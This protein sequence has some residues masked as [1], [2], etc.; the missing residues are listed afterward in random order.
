VSASPIPVVTPERHICVDAGRPLAQQP[1]IGHNR[2]HPDLEPVLSVSPGDTFTLETIDSSD[3][4]ITPSTSVS[5][6]EAFPMGR[7][8]PLTG[9]V[10]VAGATPGDV[11]E[12]EILD[13]S[14]GPFGSAAITPGEGLLPD[15]LEAPLLALFELSD[16]GARSAQLPGITVPAAMFPGVLGVAP[17]AAEVRAA[18]EREEDGLDHSARREIAAA[19]A[20]IPT[21][22]ADG[23]RTIPPR[24]NGGNI[25]VKELTA[26]ARL[27]LPVAVSGALLSTGDLH[28]AQG[29]GELAASSIEMSGAVTM[30]CHVHPRPSWGPSA[31]LVI[32]PSRTDAGTVLTV[33]VGLG[34]YHRCAAAGLADAAREAAERMILWL[35]AVTE[36][37]TAQAYLLLSIAGNLKISQLVNDPNPVVCLSLPHSVFDTA[38]ERFPIEKV[39][40]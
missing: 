36:L 20:A 29:D 24:Y 3:A 1:E 37:S 35:R 32:A 26:G 4:F 15:I 5:D 33:G 7:V 10:H 19:G 21:S 16:R 14:A 39:R 34:A 12:V 8:H 40:G 23:L 27:F 11:L 25:D 2:W 31:P 13:V 18:R 9:P 6:L 28:F 17:S 30:R 38:P 22:C